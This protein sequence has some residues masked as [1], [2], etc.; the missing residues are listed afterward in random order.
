MR[1]KTFKNYFQ[2]LVIVNY[3]NWLDAS[4]TLN[5]DSCFR[6]FFR[7]YFPNKACS[8]KYKCEHG[9]ICLRSSFYADFLIIESIWMRQHKW[10]KLINFI[11]RLLFDAAVVLIYADLCLM[12]LMRLLFDD[13]TISQLIYLHRTWQLRWG[14]QGSPQLKRH[15]SPWWRKGGHNRRNQTELERFS[16]PYCETPWTKMD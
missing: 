12:Q 16:F 5:K 1:T 14:Y 4:P 15:W 10:D 2:Y 13:N 11:P 3:R 6:C 9:G 7:S 8:Q